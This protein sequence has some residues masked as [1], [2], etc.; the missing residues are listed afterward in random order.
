MAILSQKV[1]SIITSKDE[2]K[3]AGEWEKFTKEK[4]C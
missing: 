2:E 4:K 3:V 1:C